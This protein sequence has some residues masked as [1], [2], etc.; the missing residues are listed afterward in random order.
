V[1]RCL[2]LKAE[3]ADDVRV[4][5]AYLQDAIVPIGEIGWMRE[6]GRFV[7]VANRFKWETCEPA[8]V[9]PPA[10]RKPGFP[11][12]RTHAGLRIEGV[13]AVRVRGIDLKDRGQILSLLALE[14]GEGHLLL[15]FSGGGC[16]RVDAP[17]IAVRLEDLGE[18]WPT[19]RMP[20]HRLDDAQDQDRAAQ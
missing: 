16:I 4:M 1:A 11:F 9:A 19:D 6:E 15:H 5:S 12:E 18:P 10:G 3:D 7:L 2:K 8:P 17:A 20:A 14:A 13:T